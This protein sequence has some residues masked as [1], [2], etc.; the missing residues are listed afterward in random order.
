MED[1]LIE[2]PKNMHLQ[3]LINEDDWYNQYDLADFSLQYGEDNTGRLCKEHDEHHIRQRE[4]ERRAP[5]SNGLKVAIGEPVMNVD[6]RR[7]KGR[8][9][10]RRVTSNFK[11]MFCPRDY[12]LYI[13]HDH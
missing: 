10:F 7:F 8:A 2:L 4:R 3:Y 12:L 13:M 11:F 9:V 5:V 6:E 1:K